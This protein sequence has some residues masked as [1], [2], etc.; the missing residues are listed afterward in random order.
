MNVACLVP[1]PLDYAPSQRFRVEQWAKPLASH[2][3]NVE[4]VPFLR[5]ETMA[6]LYKPGRIL[7]KSRDMIA[8]VAQRA[9][10]SMRRAREFDVVIIHR[11]AMLL[12]V[13]WVE[14]YLSKQVPTV[15]DFDDAVWLPNVSKANRAVGFLKGF[16]KINRILGMVTSVSAGCEYLANRARMFNGDVHIVPTSIDL[17]VYSPPRVHADVTTLTVGWTG[18]VT[19]APYLD[20][21][22]GALAKAA[23]RIPMRVSVL[24]A[25][26]VT[27]PGVDVECQEWTPEREVPVIRTFDV[28]IKPVPREDWV[29]GKCPMKDIQYMALGIPCVAT[30][31]G[32]SLESIE[33]GHNGFLCDTDDDWGDALEKLLDS[34]TRRAMGEAGRAVVLARYSSHVAAAAFA[35]TLESAKKRFRSRG[36]RAPSGAGALV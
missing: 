16:D 29:R 28:G 5:P 30:K 32:T 34:K 9:L 14:R 17:D 6:F 12:G 4:F 1:Y 21:I 24:G 33:P 26:S 31:F 2:G 7:E 27:L 13:D 10:W 35:E 20:Q 8:G 23:A 11:E 18:S 25:K 36:A 3:V 22:A 15:F 19:T